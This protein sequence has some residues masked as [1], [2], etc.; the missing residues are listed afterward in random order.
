[1]V[2]TQQI[3]A[4]PIFFFIAGRVIWGMNVIV[5][6]NA[7]GLRVNFEEIGLPGQFRLV[8]EDPANGTMERDARNVLL[9]DHGFVVIMTANPPP[10]A[11]NQP[12]S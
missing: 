9:P 7:A 6:V 1:M 2:Y 10:L 12:A 11:E 3:D 4:D 8:H 5:D